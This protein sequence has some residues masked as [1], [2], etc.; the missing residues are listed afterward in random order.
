MQRLL[1][2]LWLLQAS[3]AW[4]A[5]QLY[6]GEETLLQDT[7]W[8]GEIL[9]DGILTVP[10]GV[11]LEIRPGTVIRFTLLDSN[12]DGIGEHEIFLQ[13]SLRALGTA[14][15]PILFTAAGKDPHPGAWG[16]INIMGSEEDNRLEHCRV[17]FAYRG[18]HAHFSRA[19]LRDCEFSHN[20]RAMQFQ[21]ATVRIERC[22][23]VENLN[24]VQFRDSQVV[25]ADSLL[26]DNYWGLRCVYSRLELR[27]CRLT[28]NLVNG[29]NL[30]DSQ[31]VIEGN[32]IGA[33]R[34]GLYLQRTRASVQ[35]NLLVGNSEHGI[36]LEDSEADLRQ[37]RISANG[38]AGIR[39]LNSRGMVRENALAGNGE[40]ALVNDG[41]GTVDAR[42]NWWGTPL[43]SEI[44]ARIRD[45]AARPGVGAVDFSAP[46]AHAPALPEWINGR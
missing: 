26:A 8:E 4:G 34:K 28:D 41:S 27:G 5:S 13:G 9:I 30:R 46:L 7:V 22:R 44:A 32:H 42:D 12:G 6:H 37:N 15:A 24:G 18:F 43:A 21:E 16:A 2:L 17:E 40:Y 23:I 36:F 39:W 14:A 19:E 38:R 29:A 3:T 45:A 31:A 25:I 35:G 20:V 1:L 10:P 11:T 33:N